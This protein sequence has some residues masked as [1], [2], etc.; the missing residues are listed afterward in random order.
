M[1][2]GFL[3]AGVVAA[4]AALWENVDVQSLARRAAAVPDDPPDP[5]IEAEGP[6]AAARILAGIAVFESAASES[7][8]PDSTFY[9]AAVSGW[10]QLE[11]EESNSISRVNDA[12]GIDELPAGSLLLA[13]EAVCV[14]ERELEAIRRHLARGGGLVLNWATA[15]RDEGCRWRGW[16]DR[17]SVV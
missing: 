5:G 13:P 14:S 8:F 17:K 16:G 10:E 7:F 3:A 11:R 9:P 15:A 4:A 1:L 12:A 6:T 2:L